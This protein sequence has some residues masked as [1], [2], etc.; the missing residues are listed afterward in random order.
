MGYNGNHVVSKEERIVKYVG[1]AV[2]LNAVYY[3]VGR[4]AKPATSLYIQVRLGLTKQY[5]NSLLRQL[6]ADNW[7]ERTVSDNGR[8]GRPCY[9]YTVADGDAYKDIHAEVLDDYITARMVYA[10]NKRSEK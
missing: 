10:R 7:L 2:N 6:V 9:L 8:T 5:T 3:L 1:R 4:S